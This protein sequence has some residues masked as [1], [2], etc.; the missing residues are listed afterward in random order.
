MRSLERMLNG[1]QLRRHP[2]R[3]S[4]VVLSIALGVGAWV[5]TGALDRSLTRAVGASA[6]P[7]EGEADLHVSNGEA[8]VHRELIEKV[9]AVPGVES[10]EPVIIRRVLLPQ[11]GGRAATLLGVD[12]R[13]RRDRTAE[14]GIE[15]SAGAPR[16]LMSARLR[17]RKPVLLGHALD[18]ALPAA[19]KNIAIIIDGETRHVRRAGTIEAHGRSAALSGDVLVTD[20]KVAA[21]LL[22]RRDLVSRLDITLADAAPLAETRAKIA[23]ALAGAAQVLL[24]ESNDDRVRDL[25]AGLQVG[26]SLCGASA[27]ILGLFLVHNV[28]AVGVAERRREIGVLRSLGATRRQIA[29]LFLSEAACLGLA[30]VAV[31]LPLGYGL[32]YCALGPLGQT[33]SEVFLPVDA[34]RPEITVALCVSGALAGLATAIIAALVPAMRA[35]ALPPVEAASQEGISFAHRPGRLLAIGPLVAVLLVVAAILLQRWLPAHVASYGVVAISLVGTLLAI[36]LLTAALMRAARPV[37]SLLFGVVGRLAADGL[38]SH[39]GRCGLTIAACAI[40]VALIFQ[41]AGVIHG[42]E[43]AVLRWIEQGISGDL[44]VTSGGPLS[45]SGQNLPMPDE[46]G[47]EL[48]H[49]FPEARIVPLRFRYL[50]WD[51]AGNATRV[52]MLAIDADRYYEANRRLEPPVVDLDLYRQLRE[53]GTVIV[54]ENF[55]ALNDVHAGETISLP[56]AEGPVELRVLGTVPDFSCSQGTVTIDRERYGREFHAEQVDIYNFYLPKSADLEATRER[57]L[58][59]PLAAGRALSVLSHSEVRSHILGIVDRLYGVAYVQEAVAVL[60]AAMGVVTTLLISV[61]HRR[62][63]IGLLRAVGATQAQVLGTV[64]AEGLLMGVIGVALGLL[65]GIPLEWYVLKVVLFE[66]SGFV[67]PVIFPWNAAAMIAAVVVLGGAVAG[68]VPA[69]SAARLS[70]PDAIA[71]E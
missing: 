42:N 19:R 46:W 3:M 16:A 30:G 15:V 45:A 50:P 20:W 37:A 26:F 67:F 5:A 56:G 61:L 54:S 34:R 21:S 43:Q 66:E 47:E 27:L 14:A 24:P 71:F 49:D 23:A 59:S 29:W 9:A 12:L 68:I 38:E 60:V 57:I 52:L 39:P 70:I 65:I 35:A 31:G 62:R 22:P 64:L 48:R 10:V 17:G 69:W 7:L 51:H 28:L 18:A 58:H 36:P 13:A 41:T 32:A 63:E 6:M 11:L 4:L 53:P 25:L 44:F 33:I 2:A 55:A 1:K 8:G 40:G